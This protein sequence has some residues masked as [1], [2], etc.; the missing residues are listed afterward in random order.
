MLEL[1]IM[2][3]PYQD[4]GPLIGR[5]PTLGAVAVGRINASRGMGPELAQLLEQAPWTIPCVVLAP[6][7]VTPSTLQSVW[8]LPGQ[9]AFVVL[10]TP[11]DRLPGAVVIAAIGARPIPPAS[12]LISYVVR[13]THSV[14]LGQT[15]EAV[16][17]PDWPHQGTAERTI[18]HRFHRLGSHG[19]HDW[20]RI[21][22]LIRA[23]T[24]GRNMTMEQR[25][26]LVGTEARTL[27]SWVARYLGVSMKTFR[28]TAGWEWILELALRRG[29]FQLED[30]GGRLASRMAG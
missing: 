27:R 1:S 6:A 28:A 23:K 12:L 24:E 15:L 30:A 19:P 25:A 2:E 18:R 7:S 14:L 17:S 22:R 8:G 21:H 29:G 20:I 11:T 5:D 10:P 16:W 26:Q 4:A 13:R 3:P 9:P